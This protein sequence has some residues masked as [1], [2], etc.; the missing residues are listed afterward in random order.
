MEM[1]HKGTERRSMTG[2]ILLVGLV[3][4]EKVWRTLEAQSLRAQSNERSHVGQ[5][6]GMCL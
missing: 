4:R 1:H 3:A 5:D 2:L 6:M